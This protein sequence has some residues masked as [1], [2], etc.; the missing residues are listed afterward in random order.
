MTM[1]AFVYC[2]SNIE[3]GRKYIGYHKGSVDDG[4]VSSSKCDDFWK[5]YDSGKLKRQIVAVGTTEDCVKFESRILS[6]CNV[7]HKRSSAEFYNAN[8]NGKIIFNA[9]VRSKMR[10]AWAKKK[11]RGHI[12]PTSQMRRNGLNVERSVAARK[13]KMW[14]NDGVVSKF[15]DVVPE[16]WIKGRAPYDRSNHVRG[17]A[18]TEASTR[19]WE[20]RRRNLKLL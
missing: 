16:G 18:A 2:W 9:D 20:T 8:L 12:Q 13:G 15:S 6:A 19:G 5:D 1:D 11:A 3:T 10:A 14:I 7:T 17:V 4:Y